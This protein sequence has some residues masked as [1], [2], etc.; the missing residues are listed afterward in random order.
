MSL[1]N[2]A[3]WSIFA[4]PVNMASLQQFWIVMLVNKSRTQDVVN[5][6]LSRGAHLVDLSRQ[7]QGQLW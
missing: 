3:L 6:E 7:R 1:F 4:G 5:T 2:Y